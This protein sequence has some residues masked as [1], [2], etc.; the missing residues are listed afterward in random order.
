MSEAYD[1]TR[2]MH[3]QGANYVPETARYEE[4]VV[5]VRQRK[6]MKEKKRRRRSG[7]KE[8]KSRL[9]KEVGGAVVEGGA[10]REEMAPFRKSRPPKLMTSIALLFLIFPHD[11][12][13]C[14]RLKFYL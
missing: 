11:Q 12:D 10:M 5:K 2:E 8:N 4:E 13:E 14:Y 1:N 9:G 7:G 3:K 6:V